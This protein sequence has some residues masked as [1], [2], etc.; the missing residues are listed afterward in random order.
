MRQGLGQSHRQEQTLK[1][2]PRVVL[3]SQLLKLT[4][5]ELDQAIDAELQ[6][7]P[8]LERLEEDFE[9]IS[10]EALMRAVAP[11]ELRVHHDD[12]EATRSLPNDEGELDWMDLATSTPS[13]TDH[14]NAQLL[15]KLPAEF[16]HIGVYTVECVNDHGYLVEP[17]EEIALATNSSIEEAEFVIAKLKECDPPGIGA[18]GIQECL[19]LQLKG[20][21][22]HEGKLAQHI[23]K[24]HLDEFRSRNTMKLAR[25]FGVM[26]ELVESS[27]AL[28]LS[29]EP[30]PGQGF[31]PS[32]QRVR[33]AMIKPDMIFRR[34]EAGWEVEVNGPDA[35]G[36]SINRC[37]RRQYDSLK[38][39]ASG[40][41]DEKRHISVYLDRAQT[42]IDCLRQR[43]QTM[44]KIGQFLL[45]HQL[46]FIA[47]GDYR[48]LTALT[49]SQ[50]ARVI[51]VHESTISRATSDKF[52]QIG[53]GEVISF[54]VF[55]KP[56]LRVQKMIEEIL[57]S[58][59]PSNP[60]S[61]ERIAELLAEQGVV[62]ARR[63][64]NKYRDRTRLLSSRKRRMA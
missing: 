25:K 1:I 23:V 43:Q 38:T 49:R 40:D 9:S 57:S 45:Q 31:A 36:F 35:T 63:T 29:L 16:R 7:N 18:S 60:L 52:V 47:T 51:L 46:G 19:G 11:Q 55:F 56:A 62:V 17:P 10:D 58:E 22:T 15:P 8:A 27:Y 37:Y 6:E 2:D 14:L 4:Q 54:D 33:P 59:N 39:K 48:F 41:K 24:N 53:N 64:V 13:L 50:I 44:E 34:S 30:F 61:D 28:I 12:F 5:A 26:P 32:Q 21:R 42:F 3:G 20:I